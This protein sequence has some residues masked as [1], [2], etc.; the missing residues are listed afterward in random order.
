MAKTHITRL[1]T[2]AHVIN[3]SNKGQ[4]PSFL[5][6][7]KQMSFKMYFCPLQVAQGGS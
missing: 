7:Q 5:E 6:S 4:E 1:N 2:M 3:L